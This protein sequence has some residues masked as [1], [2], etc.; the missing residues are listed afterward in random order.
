MSIQSS[1][2][3]YAIATLSLAAPAL[4]QTPTPEQ[5]P[6]TLDEVNAATFSPT[7]AK[8]ASSQPGDQSDAPAMPDPLIVK[9]Q[10]LLDRASVSPGV[11][12]GF[13][14][15]NVSKAIAAFE[16]EHGLPEDGK[17][18]ADVFSALDTKPA[19]PVLVRYTIT[20][21]D[22]AGPFVASIPGDYGEWAKMDLSGYTSP[23]EMFAERFHMDEDLLAALNPDVDF[24]S[25]GTQIVVADPGDDRQQAEL[26]RIEVDRAR[27]SLRAYDANGNEVLFYPAT[28]GSLDNQSPS[29]TH[30]VQAVAPDPVYYYRPDVNFQQG[31]NDKPLEIPPGPNNP[32]GSTWIDLSEPTY[33]I[34]GTPEPAK[35]D[36]TFSHGCVRLTNWDVAELSRLVK[37]GLTVQFVN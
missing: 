11:I 33:G 26:A 24:S 3:A 9:L 12:D 18:D 17:L 21:K 31:D 13:E 27:G 14:G 34:H 22:L 16:R 8:M 29:G 4:A 25:E 19:S 20:A 37:K 32:V 28:I 10:V 35:I 1:I 7:P 23:Q 30:T 36:K 6:L 5:Q 15:E 2:F